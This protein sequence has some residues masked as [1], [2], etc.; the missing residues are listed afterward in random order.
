MK[1]LFFRLQHGAFMNYKSTI[2]LAVT[3]IVA[4]PATLLPSMGPSK[5]AKIDQAAPLP[6]GMSEE[7]MKM[8]AEFID[9]LDQETI[10][11]LTAIGEEIIK[12]A[13]EL[14]VDPFEY[15]ELQAQMQKEME[16]KAE[17]PLKSEPKKDQTAPIKPISTINLAD[18]QNI[19]EIFKGIAKIVSSIMQK[20]ASDI[21]L[22]N[23]ILPFKYRLDDLIFYATAL[24]NDKM[25]KHL[26]D[27]SFA[28]L[29]D[30]AKKLYLDLSKLND[31]FI[32][33]EFSLEGT[34]PYE[35]LDLPKTASQQDI[36]KAFQK[37]TKSID[38]DL[39]EL[40][41]IR[42]GKT[43]QEIKVEVEKARKKLQAIN[44]AYAMLRNQ[45]ESKYILENILN[46]VAQAIDSK[47]MLEEAKKVIQK[48]DPEAAKLKQEQEKTEGEARKKQEEFI[49]K[50][51]IVTRSFKMP[52]AKLGKTSGKK[53]YD[54][55]G[56]YGDLGGSG[57]AKEPKNDFTPTTLPTKKSDKE[58]GKKKE[59]KDK[60]DKEE[61]KEKGKD[62]KGKAGKPADQT[63]KG[64]EG[65][66]ELSSDVLKAV[67]R[68]EV[69]FDGLKDLIKN[70]K[71]LSKGEGFVEEEEEEIVKGHGL[72]EFLTRDLKP[73]EGSEP[74]RTDQ[75]QQQE[76]LLEAQPVIK[77]INELTHRFKT[78][79]KSIKKTLSDKFKDKKDEENQF[80][81]EV[82]K[83]FNKFEESNEY[84]S[85]RLLLDDEHGLK[86]NLTSIVKNVS[87][88]VTAPGPTNINIPKKNAI[89]NASEATEKNKEE[90]EGKEE[91]EGEPYIKTLRDF[92]KKV[93]K[94][95]GPK[96]GNNKPGQPGIIRSPK[97]S[98]TK[99]TKK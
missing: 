38:P 69:E 63:A 12:E 31:Q 75:D 81:E 92:Y 25:L 57:F 95:V 41:L 60:K 94:L 11:A 88:S 18:A 6:P 72:P 21:N 61:K 23:A 90:G 79:E 80:K 49:K 2:F 62:T 51:P 99:F 8:F 26:N 67:T 37:L 36:I 35:A 82:A 32:V 17:K 53:S 66:K 30:T 76:A 52:P 20:A 14:G 15:I 87:E 24:A 13:D 3:F 98:A 58:Q 27:P 4:I 34:N 10:D 97:A 85:V 42:D 45:E 68:I 78:M 1:N 48:Y 74:K 71:F 5:P 96:D 73:A 40:Q 28:T 44:D 29:N 93:K 47:K 50:R 91:E 43:D 33:H 84:K 22:A 64:K 55:F 83:L 46:S 70:N 16:E 39:L 86:D 7:D 59:D 56:N 9:S 89:L 65:K 77:L 54:D 19:Q